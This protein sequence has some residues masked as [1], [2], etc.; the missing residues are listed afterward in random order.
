MSCAVAFIGIENLC[1]LES[2]II[3]CIDVITWHIQGL[4]SLDAGLVNS[5]SRYE[6]YLTKDWFPIE[7]LFSKLT[8]IEFWEQKPDDYSDNRTYG[9]FPSTSMRFVLKALGK[10]AMVCNQDNGESVN[11]NIFETFFFSS[12]NL[13]KSIF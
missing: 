12:C 7:H 2:D 9:S 6:D 5:L 1:P 10:I 13:K 11:N 3:S 4:F 8:L